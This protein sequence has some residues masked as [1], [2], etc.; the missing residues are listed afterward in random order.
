LLTALRPSKRIAD[1]TPSIKTIADGTPPKPQQGLRV[2]VDNSA[3]RLQK[4]IRNA[5]LAKVPLNPL[6]TSQA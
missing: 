3:E 2:E 5:E 1:G 4:K 6:F